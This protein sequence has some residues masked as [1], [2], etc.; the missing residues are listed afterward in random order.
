MLTSPCS[1]GA[2]LHKNV[3]RI[4][5]RSARLVRVVPEKALGR[6]TT[7]SLAASLHYHSYRR[8]VVTKPGAFA[9]CPTCVKPST[10]PS[11]C[12]RN[13]TAKAIAAPT[14]QLIQ[15]TPRRSNREPALDPLAPDN[16][17]RH[18]RLLDPRASSR[19]HR[20]AR[21]PPRFDLV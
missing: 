5:S 19:R 10:Q 13:Q 9:T 11:W 20:A 8:S 6:R 1:S 4:K 21:R 16:P 18:S 14:P 2:T 7:R 17:L 15:A 12:H 3:R